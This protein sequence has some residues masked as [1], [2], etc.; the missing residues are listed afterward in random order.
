M[1]TAK[2][3]NVESTGHG[4]R[5]SYKDALTVQP[6]NFYIEPDE[7]SLDELLLELGDGIMITEL[8]GLHSGVSEISGDFSVAAKGFVIEEGQVKSATNQLTIAGNFF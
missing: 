4:F 3:S 2:K 6:S 7:N 5:E 1:K 8:S